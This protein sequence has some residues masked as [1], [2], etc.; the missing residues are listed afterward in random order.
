[1]WCLGATA[2]GTCGLVGRQTLN[3]HTPSFVITIEVYGVKRS[4]SI[5]I[6]LAQ[7]DEVYFVKWLSLLNLQN[8]FSKSVLKVLMGMNINKKFVKLDTN[9]NL[10]WFKY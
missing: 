3:D 9:L 4:Q 8:C 2:R 1:M 5:T 7:F 6:A 10:C